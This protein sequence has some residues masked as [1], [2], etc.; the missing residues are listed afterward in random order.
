MALQNYQ[1]AIRGLSMLLAH[2]SRDPAYLVRFLITTLLCYGFETLNSRLQN[3][4]IHLNAACKTLILS[5]ATFLD[6][7]HISVLSVLTAMFRRLD[8]GATMRFNSRPQV[9]QTGIEGFVH[10]T[11]LEQFE[12]LQDARV[13][14]EILQCRVQAFLTLDIGRQT[15]DAISLEKRKYLMQELLAFANRLSDICQSPDDATEHDKLWA[16]YLMVFIQCGAGTSGGECRYDEYLS[17]FEMITQHAQR[18]VI[19]LR[20]RSLA[21]QA[22]DH[23]SVA[24]N[25]GLANTLY[26]VSLKCRD[27]FLRYR[28]LDLLQEVLTLERSQCHLMLLLARAAVQEEEEAAQTTSSGVQAASIPEYDRVQDVTLHIHEGQRSGRIILTRVTQDGIIY[29]TRR[30][31]AW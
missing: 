20:A 12:S 17:S 14:L 24:I 26:F 15:K 1:I 7:H 21:V 23:L 8:I 25:A 11:N 13:A 6:Y 4:F 19:D 2:N 3:A 31:L 27:G 5:P 9:F 28:A 16:H 22:V 18:V 30:K 29:E 10:S